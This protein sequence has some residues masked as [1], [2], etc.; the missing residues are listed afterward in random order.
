MMEAM[1]HKK[2]GD[3]ILEVFP[4][5]DPESPREW[6]NLGK[7]EMYHRQYAF[8]H[9]GGFKDDL[10]GLEALLKS[11]SIAV[12]LP[13]YMYEHSGITIRTFS[14]NDRWDSGHIGYIY[15]TKEDIRKNWNKKRISKKLLS[16]VEECLKG[17]IETYDTYLRGNIVG[18]TI[19]KISTCSHG[20]EHKDHLDSCWG[21]YDRD[22]IM[23]NVD[24]KWKSVEWEDS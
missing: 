20:D 13:I 4:D 11:D 14:F 9:E 15:A 21:F 7:I 8:P 10:E 22:D 1:Y 17:E 6:D 18:F 2:I 12:V 23:D 16:K 3:E 24:E 19:S 5:S